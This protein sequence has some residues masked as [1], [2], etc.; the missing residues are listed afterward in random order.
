M[1]RSAT[2]KFTFISG[3]TE[4]AMNRSLAIVLFILGAGVA[5]LAALGQAVPGYM[6]A[7][8]YTAGALRLV[9]G[10]G[11]TEPFLWNYL[12]NPTGLPHPSHLYWMPLASILAAMGMKAFG[13]TS[14][15]A[16]RL[17]FILL[18]GMLPV[19]SAYL[20]LKF[21]KNPRYAWV[22]GLLAVFSGVYL[23]YASI[24]ETFVLYLVLGGL[25]WLLIM[26]NDWDI[27]GAKTVAFRAGLIGILVGLMHLSRADGIV[28]VAGGSL[29]FIWVGIRSQETQKLRVVMVGIWIFLLAYA[30]VMSA[31]YARNLDLFGTLMAAGNSRT[32]WITNYDQTFSFPA[33]NLTFANWQAAGLRAHLQ[34]RWDA[35]IMN[36]KNLV[37]VQGLVIL[38]PLMIAGL[39]H[40]RRLPGIQFAGLMGLGTLALMTLVFPYAGARGGYLHSASAFQTLLWAA[41]A[42]GLERFVAWGQGKRNWQPDRATPV[43]AT[44]LIIV[45]AFIT[46]WFYLTKVIG[47]GEPAARWGF[48]QQTYQQIGEKLSDFGVAPDDMVMVNNPPGFYLATGRTSIVIPGGGVEQSLAAAKEFGAKWLLLGESQGNLTDLYGQPGDTPGMQYRGDIGD[49]RIFCIDCE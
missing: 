16:A 34:S 43:F 6:D 38:T 21:L 22:A 25:I 47:T 44:L 9:Q 4:A 48:S 12:D 31:W 18:Y 11:F 32:L 36:L 41:T 23:V 19:I 13:T 7:E 49:L 2:W 8:Y 35:L 14:F 46:G 27:V 45:A 37:A 17:P 15:W 33:S 20:S 29:W 42:V 3:S 39:W 30:L 1:K 26:Q 10:D 5:A 24:P 28:W 40:K